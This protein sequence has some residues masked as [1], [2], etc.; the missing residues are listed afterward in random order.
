MIFFSHIHYFK[1]LGICLLY[2]ICLGG[3]TV[4]FQSGNI[5]CL[6]LIFIYFNEC[7]FGLKLCYTVINN[8]GSKLALFWL[9]HTLNLIW[10]INSFHLTSI[11]LFVF[12]WDFMELNAQLSS[13]L[14]Q[15]EAFI[16]DCPFYTLWESTCCCIALS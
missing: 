4:V 11:I 14:A 7:C 2:T 10:L 1:P 9:F 8:T 12:D 3:G 5:I 16:L 15:E 6:R 13:Q